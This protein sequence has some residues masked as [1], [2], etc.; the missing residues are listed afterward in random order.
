MGSSFA[1]GVPRADVQAAHQALLAQLDA[2]KADADAGLAA[3]LR[4]ELQGSIRRYEDLKAAHGAL[5]FLDLLLRTRDLV[6]DRQDVRTHFQR[7]FSCIFV[8]EFQDTDPLQAELLLLLAADDPGER[9]AARVRPLPGK[10]FVVGDPKQSIYRFRRADVGVY[11]DVC[12][13]LETH[14]ARRER[15]TTSFRGVPNLQR[16]INASF[17]PLMTGDAAGSTA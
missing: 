14:G 12:A 16:A 15:L 13:Q 17:A 5:D 9:E 4:D 1:K 2:F 10:L 6:R 3:L 8:D 11:T 7:R